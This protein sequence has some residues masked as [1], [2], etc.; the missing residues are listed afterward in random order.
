MAILTYPR[1]TQTKEIFARAATILSIVKFGL[2][3]LV[4]VFEIA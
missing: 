4:P 1:A 2:G 3:E